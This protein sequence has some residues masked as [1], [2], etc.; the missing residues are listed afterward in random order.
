MATGVLLLFAAVAALSGTIVVCILS[1][2]AVQ[3]KVLAV[4][5]LLAITTFSVLASGFAAIRK[6]QK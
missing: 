1:P 5:V 6:G 2:Q 4:V 3:G